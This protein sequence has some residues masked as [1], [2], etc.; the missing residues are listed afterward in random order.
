LF[1]MPSF[2]N[3]HK[4]ST[5]VETTVCLSSWPKKT[6][7]STVKPCPI[8]TKNIISSSND[9]SPNREIVSPLPSGHLETANKFWQFK[10]EE[11]LITYVRYGSIRADGSLKE[12]A[13]HVQHHS[14][15]LD[16]K[17]F[18]E[19]IVDEKIKAGY[20]GWSRW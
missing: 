16:A 1:F 17:K 11:G 4:M 5:T 3:T 2:G 7:K 14:S 10:V 12:R 18:V 15:Y 6:R 13:I 8:Y 19:N 20:V 9:N